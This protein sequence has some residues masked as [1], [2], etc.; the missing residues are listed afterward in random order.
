MPNDAVIETAF[1]TIALNGSTTE[2]KAR[3]SSTSIT[4]TTIRPIQGRWLPDRG[5][6]VD[7]VGGECRRPAPARGGLDRAQVADDVLGRSVWLLPSQNARSSVVSPS[8]ADRL[9]GDDAVDRLDLTRCTP[10]RP[11]RRRR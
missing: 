7:G 11:P 10:P 5:D 3:N 4:P 9:D 2:P 6:Q 8:V 1:I